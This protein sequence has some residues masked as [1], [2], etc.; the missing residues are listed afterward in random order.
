MESKPSVLLCGHMVSP[1]IAGEKESLLNDK[2]FLSHASKSVFQACTDFT[3]C[4]RFPGTA[5]L[6]DF[7]NFILI[8]ISSNTYKVSLFFAHR[9]WEIII[10]QS[11]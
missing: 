2:E 4:Q 7:L 11:L 8:F 3:S 6:L 5:T 1:L 9:D 10:S